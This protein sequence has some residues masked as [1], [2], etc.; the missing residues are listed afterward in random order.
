MSAH[1]LITLEV[2][3]RLSKIKDF[4]SGGKGDPTVRKG[5]NFSLYLKE[6]NEK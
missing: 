2:K 6:I 5:L 3:S 4:F 1:L